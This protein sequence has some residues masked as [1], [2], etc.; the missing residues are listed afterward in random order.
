MTTLSK[1]ETFYFD[2]QHIIVAYVYDE[3]TQEDHASGI[4]VTFP[5]EEFSKKDLMD[6]FYEVNPSH[7]VAIELEYDESL[8]MENFTEKLGDLMEQLKVG[9]FTDLT[10]NYYIP[11]TI[12]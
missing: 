1:N 12:H 5:G 11:A 10:V 9:D 3:A 4:F 2:E 6:Y 7:L 8:S